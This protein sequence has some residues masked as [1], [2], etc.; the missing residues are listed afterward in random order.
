MPKPYRKQVRFLKQALE[1]GDH[2]TVKLA[3]ANLALAA[4][5]KKIDAQQHPD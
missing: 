4:L 5:I 2:S 3:I 1:E